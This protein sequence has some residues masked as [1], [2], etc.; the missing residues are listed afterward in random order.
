MRVNTKAYGAI[1]VDD[2][3]KIYFPHGILGFEKL[4][5]YVLLDAPQKPFYWLQS[6]DVVEIA[7]VLIDPSLF[8]TD[9]LISVPQDELDEI[10]IAETDDMLTFAIVTIPENAERMTANLQGPVIINRKSRVGRQSINNDQRWKVRHF[11][12]E[13]LAALRQQ[14]AS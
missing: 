3:Q 11:I 5:D 12:M 8:R 9:Y 13:E 10:G 6:M 14:G 7:F 2:R 4:K 1:D